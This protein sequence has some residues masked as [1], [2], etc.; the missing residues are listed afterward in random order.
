MLDTSILAPKI[1]HK[2]HHPARVEGRDPRLFL[3][4]SSSLLPLMRFNS[5]T[6]MPSRLLLLQIDHHDEQQR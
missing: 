3:L 6:Q 2:P 5:R 1:V 4:H